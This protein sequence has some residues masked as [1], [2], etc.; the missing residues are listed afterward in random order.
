VTDQL[1]LFAEAEP[2]RN[3]PTGEARFRMARRDY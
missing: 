3:G 1:S 2:R